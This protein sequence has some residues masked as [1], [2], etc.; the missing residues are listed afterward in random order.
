MIVLT[1]NP[2]PVGASIARPP[3]KTRSDVKRHTSAKTNNTIITCRADAITTTAVFNAAENRKN[4]FGNTMA[5]VF[6]CLFGK[7]L[8]C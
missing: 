2:A 5:E 1:K 4:F 3:V 8:L 6:L 7:R